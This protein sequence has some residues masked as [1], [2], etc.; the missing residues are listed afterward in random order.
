[1]RLFVL[2]GVFLVLI[3]GS[4]LACRGTTEF[5]QVNEQLQSSTLP[6]DR[7]DALL[8]QLS[9]GTVMHEEAHQQGDM[10]K[11]GQSIRILDDVKEKMNQ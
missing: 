3:S 5:P 7:L 8:E 11:M 6:P 9:L 10:S 2:T 4:A 1:M